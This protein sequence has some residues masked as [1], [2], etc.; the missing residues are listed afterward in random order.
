MVT[1]T[2]M[3]RLRH[4]VAFAVRNLTPGGGEGGL[5]HSEKPRKTSGRNDT[6]AEACWVQGD[7]QAKRGTVA[8]FHLVGPSCS[9]DAPSCRALEPCTE[10]VLGLE[11]LTDCFSRVPRFEL[12]QGS[13][14]RTYTAVHSWG[15]D[16]HFWPPKSP[17]TQAY[18]VVYWR[19][20][21][22]R[23]KKKK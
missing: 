2:E 5:R 7:P 17:D 10:C 13:S 3:S 14:P 1:G 23:L 6:P 22:Q 19:A 21:R 12:S 20:S 8:V 18:T 4:S 15:S 9:L 16:A 11:W